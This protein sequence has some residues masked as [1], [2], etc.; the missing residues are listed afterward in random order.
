MKLTE[1]TQLIDIRQYVVNQTA[2]FSIDKKITRE[3]DGI[4]LLL[5]KKI[6]GIITGNEFKAY[7][8]YDSVD[9]IKQQALQNSNIYAG[10]NGRK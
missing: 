7:V 1:L 10:L 4:L 5:D 9:Q 8:D 2:N 6:L 3:L